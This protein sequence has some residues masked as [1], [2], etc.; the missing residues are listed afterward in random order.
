ML[1]IMNNGSILFTRCVSINE[2]L[3]ALCLCIIVTKLLLNNLSSLIFCII[4]H[5]GLSSCSSFIGCLLFR[6]LYRSVRSAKEK[7]VTKLFAN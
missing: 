3:L 5:H 4:N 1:I 2:K 6:M 7:I